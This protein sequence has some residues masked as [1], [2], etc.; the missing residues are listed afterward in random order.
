MPKVTMNTL[1]PDFE[2]PDF[3]GKPIRLSE[4]RSKNIF[5]VFN[6]TFQ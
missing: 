6:R 1:A 3:D 4:F 5:L 2:L